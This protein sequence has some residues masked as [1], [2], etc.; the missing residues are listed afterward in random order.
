MPR[1]NY[2]CSKEC[3]KPQSSGPIVF[4]DVSSGRAVWEETH[5]MFETPNITCPLCGA[6][7]RKTLEGVAAPVSYV[8]GNCYLNRDDCRKQMDLHALETGRD[9]YASFRQPG[10]VDHIKTQLKKP[11]RNRK[12][13][14]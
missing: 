12:I 13:I 7:A 8:R 11:K 6:P 10:E 2:V 1:Y 3:K 9:P 4:Q 5:G 14:T